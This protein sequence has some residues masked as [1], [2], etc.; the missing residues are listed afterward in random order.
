MTNTPNYNLNIV[1][2]SDLVNPLTQFNPNFEEIDEV[3][4]RNADSGIT[5]ATENKVAN[6]HRLV[7]INKDCPVFRF[8]A[9]TDFVAGETFTVDGMQVTA[10]TTGANPLS[11]NA[12][13]IGCTVICALQGTVLTLFV[14]NP[15]TQAEDSMK[16]GGQLPEYYATA[17]ALQATNTIAVNAGI[18]ANN[19]QTNL[20]NRQD[21]RMSLDGTT[22]NITF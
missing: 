17:Q 2:G 13:Q 5:L 20:N 9:T 4:K 21:I 19:V 16:L 12:Y 6:E 1:E 3:M 14:D 7:R 15:I 22:L 18:V 8:V 10:Y 11:T